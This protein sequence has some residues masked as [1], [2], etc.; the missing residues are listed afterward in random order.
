[1][2]EDLSLIISNP[3]EGEFLQKIVW[4]KEDFMK[5]VASI[6]ERYDGAMYSDDEMKDA[7]S[8]RAKL[9]A[10]KKAITG[11]CTEVK[12]TIMEPYNLF[13]KEV[14]EVVVLIDEPIALIDK[15]IKDY[16]ERC[17]AEKRKT[18]AEHFEEKV[19]ELKGMLTLDMIFDQKW[20]NVSV[21]LKKA[22]EEI[23]LK[24][25]KVETDLR[26]I[27]TLC[28]EKYRPQLKD[29]Y[30][31]GLNITATIAECSRLKEIDSREMERQER[32]AERRER[33]AEAARKKAE[34]EASVIKTEESVT[35]TA[36]NVSKPKENVS[37]TPESAS[38]S[39][40][41]ASVPVEGVTEPDEEV[42]AP[43]AGDTAV[44]DPFAPQ[45]DTKQYKASFT[46][47]GTRAEIMAVKQYMIDNNIRFRKVEK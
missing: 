27:D 36:K 10:M 17:K 38:N 31:R 29:H 18:L 45:E 5:I 26:S 1:M 22:K 43:H 14:D 9:N 4:N 41:T 39:S 2:A 33:E 28:E 19:G 46:I 23:E 8:D 32:E 20:L 35:E 24:I 21:S 40:E 13:K 47:F 7:K 12:N 25:Q 30:M 44:I 3:D 34:Q 6:T 15:Q 11:R 16:E 42:V 37:E